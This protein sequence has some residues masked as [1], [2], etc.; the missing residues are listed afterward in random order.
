MKRDIRKRVLRAFEGTAWVN[1]GEIDG[2]ANNLLS[3][4]SEEVSKARKEG[5][6]DG[7]ENGQ[8]D[9]QTIRADRKKL[10][11][12]S[13]EAVRVILEKVRQEVLIG[14]K[15]TIQEEL[16]HWETWRPMFIEQFMKFGKEG[17]KE[18]I[19]KII[20]GKGLRRMEGKL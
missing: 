20:N 15:G 16:W 19:E 13:E 14:S 17:G 9:M 2:I 18:E 10:V 12:L 8:I 7:F 1:T 5:Y 4:I 6:D 3:L 11:P